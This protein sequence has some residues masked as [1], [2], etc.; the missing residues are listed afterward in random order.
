MRGS[1]PCHDCF[2]FHSWKSLRVERKDLKKVGVVPLVEVVR[3]GM[4]AVH[5]QGVEE[6][7]LEVLPRATNRWP[8][9]L[10]VADPFEI[11]THEA[12]LIKAEAEALAVSGQH[13]GYAE[14]SMRKQ[15]EVRASLKCLLQ[16]MVE[17]ADLRPGVPEIFPGTWRAQELGQFDFVADSV[18][19]KIT[20]IDP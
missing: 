1:V 19:G 18:K 17:S 2:G 8:E 4:P 16:G 11:I 15:A 3:H 12:F 14:S 6:L 13:G 5:A 9:L 7:L 10:L 20:P